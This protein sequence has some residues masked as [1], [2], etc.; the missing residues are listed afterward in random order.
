M[1]LWHLSEA[2]LLPGAIIAP[3]RWGRRVT[4]ADKAHPFFAREW[5]LE[6]WRTTRTRVPV[7]RLACA[8][9]FDDIK[10]AE[11]YAADGTQPEHLYRVEPEIAGDP[12]VRLDMLWL[13]WMGEPQAR[14]PDVL[15]WC[16]AYWAGESTQTAKASAQPSWERI[17]AGGLRVIARDKV[18]PPSRK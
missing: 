11:R 17:F 5:L 4:D 1:D 15:R 13:T 3:G 6:Q 12:G 8:F 18:I 14:L 9:A 7:S 16:E 10:V 2:E